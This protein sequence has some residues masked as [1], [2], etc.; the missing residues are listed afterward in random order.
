MKIIES[1]EKIAFNSWSILIPI[2][3]VIFIVVLTILSGLKRG[4]Y[5]G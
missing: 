4:I 5:G 2:I 1:F 3:L